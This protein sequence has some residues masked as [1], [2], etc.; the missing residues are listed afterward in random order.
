MRNGLDVDLLRAA[1][2]VIRNLS[3]NEIVVAGDLGDRGPRLDRVID[4]LMR[5]PSVS[6]VWGNHDASWMGACLGQEA[7]IATVVRISLRVPAAHAARGGLRHHHGAGGEARAHRL[8][9]RS[10][11]RFGV[12]GEGLR[13]TLLMQRMQKA[14]AVVQFKLEGQVTRR[15]PEW[16]L[17]HRNLLHRIDPAARTITID[18]KT[19]PLLDARLPTVDFAGDP[20]ALSA[21]EEA[22]MARLQQSFL[23]SPA[24][25]EQMRWVERQGSH[26]R[27]A[28][29]GADLPG[30]VP[31]DAEGGLASFMVDGEPRRG[32]AL[33]D[34]LQR[35]VHRAFRDKARDDLDTLYYLWTGPLS[36]LFGKDRMA[37]L[38]TYLVADK[39]THK[40]T[41]NPYFAMIHDAAFCSRICE[42]MGGDRDKGLIVNG[43]VPVKIEE[44][45]SPVKRSGR[46]VTIDGAFSEAYG[47]KGYTL[48]LE[49][50]RTALAQHHHFESVDE[51]VAAG[52]DIIPSVTDLETYEAPRT[53]GDTEKGDELRLEIGL[54]EE[55]LRAYQTSVLPEQ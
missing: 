21:E 23:K 15:H 29:Q 9:G 6:I 7:L 42:E 10:A 25:W 48:V 8:R 13:D 50:G 1:A 53:V 51:A 12:K 41:K 20:Y 35:V 54:L 18:G 27:A 32:R 14:M 46:A 45:E 11:E 39:A 36:P 16:N 47:D 24:L 31:V 49:A 38:E 26:V 44:G 28:R 33:F 52:A 43:H 3:V 40:E 17:E 22:C 2:H 4:L 5:Q 34:A 19:Y 37:T 55:L 30:C